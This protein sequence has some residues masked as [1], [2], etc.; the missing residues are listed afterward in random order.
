MVKAWVD[1]L[2]VDDEAID[3]ENVWENIFHSSKN[4]NQQFI[5]L[6]LCHRSY[7]T[8]LVRFHAKQ[9]HTVT[10]VTSIDLVHTNI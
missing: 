2:A 9:T 1:D 3:W 6:K 10:Y 7:W 4:T 5:H 8:P